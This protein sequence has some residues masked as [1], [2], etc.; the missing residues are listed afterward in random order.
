MYIFIV[1]MGHAITLF[2]DLI[3]TD[4]MELVNRWRKEK[5]VLNA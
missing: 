5:K 3:Y 4:Q 2:L 1:R